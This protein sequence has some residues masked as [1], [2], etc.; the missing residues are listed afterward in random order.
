MTTVN[1]TEQLN[2][3]QHMLMSA[4]QLSETVRKNACSFW[5]NQDKVLDA[6]QAFSDGWFE[7]RHAG[8]HAALEAA[9]R[10]CKAGTPVDLVLEYQEWASGALQRV[11]TDGLACQ[12]QFMAIA[13]APR[14]PLAASVKKDSEAPQAE[15]GRISSK[16]A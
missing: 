3:M 7:R 12:Q 11:M 8:T 5:D 2:A 14:H 4:P 10:M 16:A 1:V 9:Q 6:M 13:V 15:A